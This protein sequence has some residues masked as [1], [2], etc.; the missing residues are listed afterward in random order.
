MCLREEALW[1]VYAERT[2]VERMVLF[3]CRYCNERFQTF[4]PAYDPSGVVHFSLLE[5]KKGGVATCNIEVDLWDDF[6]DLETTDVLASVHCGI[7]HAC[8][9][10]VQS[11]KDVTDRPIVRRSF[12]NHMD[13]LFRFPLGQPGIDL[14]N[15]FESVTCIESLL[16]S[17]EHMSVEYVQVARTG[18]TKFRKN[19]ISFLQD[20]P[21]FAGRVGLLR[22][23]R[24]DDRVNSNRGPG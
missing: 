15:L 21:G 12:L 14:M 10:D 18:L 24:P 6:P 11:Q 2:I 7:C 4:H 20:L 3:D 1:A 19:V 9:A 23:Y 13:P 16:V 8:A 5:H 17:L 22:N